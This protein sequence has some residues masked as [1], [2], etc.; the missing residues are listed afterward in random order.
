MAKQRQ[1]AKSDTLP[2]SLLVLALSI[3]SQ[4]GI[5]MSLN[6]AVR[7]CSSIIFKIIGIFNSF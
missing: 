6:L 4:R 3:D 7:F 2:R 5:C 1:S